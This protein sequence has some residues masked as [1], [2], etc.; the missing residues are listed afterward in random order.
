MRFFNG[1]STSDLISITPD[2]SP[3]RPRALDGYKPYITDKNDPHN[4]CDWIYR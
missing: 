1:Y 4:A 3:S 2:M